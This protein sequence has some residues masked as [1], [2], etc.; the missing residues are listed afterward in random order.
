M[1]GAARNAKTAIDIEA[2][3]RE[4]YRSAMSIQITEISDA[5]TTMMSQTYYTLFQG[6]ERLERFFLPLMTVDSSG[7]VPFA[8]I[9]RSKFLNKC[10]PKIQ[11]QARAEAQERTWKNKKLKEKD[12]QKIPDEVF[13]ALVREELQNNSE[14]N[15]R[16]YFGAIDL[17]GWFKLNTSYAA[18]NFKETYRILRERFPGLGKEQ[19]WSDL[20]DK[21][22]DL[23][24]DW[25]GHYAPEDMDNVRNAGGPK[26]ALEKWLEIVERLHSAK[27]NEEEYRA[28]QK[29]LE[30]AVMVE[31]SPIIAF[32]DLG[33]PD[34]DHETIRGA[35][36]S[37]GIRCGADC[38]LYSSKKALSERLERILSN[39]HWIPLESIGNF[40]GDDAPDLLSF[41]KDC[42]FKVKE[43]QIYCSSA[44][45]VMK[46]LE[47]RQA[48]RQAE[49]DS[50][51]Q[52]RKAEE[53]R[54]KLKL[55]ERQLEEL[56][57]SDPQLYRKLEQ[58]GTARPEDLPRLEALAKYRKGDLSQSQIQ[59]LVRTHQIVLDPSILRSA[60]GRDFIQREL[61]PRIQAMQRAG[62]NAFMVLEA[63]ARYHLYQEFDA[64]KQAKQAYGETAWTA[65]QKQDQQKAWARI[66]EM[67]SAKAAYYFAE[68]ALHRQGLLRYV[69]IP[70]PE[71]EDGEALRLFLRRNP[72]LR[73]C[74]LTC[75]V[76]RQVTEAVDPEEFP[77]CAVARV[78]KALPPAKG[79]SVCQ[80]FNQFL[81][82]AEGE[83]AVDLLDT[84]QQYYQ[85]PTEN[86]A[87]S[88]FGGN[89]PVK[90]AADEEEK[91]GSPAGEAEK[92]D[93]GA[94][95]EEKKEAAP[96]AEAEKEETPP[97]EAEEKAATPA[98][99]GE[100]AA[101][102]P[103]KPLQTGGAAGTR[104]GPA[105]PPVSKIRR[106][107]DRALP[108]SRPVLI[109]DILTTETGEPVRLTGR[110]R[111]GK[112][113]VEG[114]EGALYQ[115]DL[116]EQVAKIYHSAPDK[117][118]LTSG[119]KAKLEDM[120]AH[121][122]EIQ[123]LCWPTHL[124]HNQKGEFV[125]YLM[126]RVPEGALSFQRSVLQM[127]KPYIQEAVLPGWNRRDLVRVAQA[128]ANMTAQLHQNNILIGDVNDGNFMVH[129]GDSGTVYL[130]DCDSYQF[131]GY[132]CPVGTL[133]YTHPNTA[134]RL[135][136]K[137]DLR[138]EEF[139]RLEEEED[140]T[141]GILL[142]RILML[143]QYPFDT[144]NNELSPAEAMRQKIFPFTVEEV[145]DIPEGDSWMIWKNMPQKLTK[146]FLDTFKEWKPPSAREWA[147]LLGNYLYSIDHYGYSRELSP[148]KYMEFH[149]EAP[150]FQDVVCEIDQVEFNMPVRQYERLVKQKGHI[151]CNGCR[152]FLNLSEKRPRRLTCEVCGKL[153]TGND[154]QLYLKEKLGEPVY[155]PEH[156][157][158]S[159][160]CEG[161]GEEYSVP[162]KEQENQSSR[163]SYCPQ[164]R[165]TEV[166]ACEVC[167]AEYGAQRGAYLNEKRYHHPG[168]CP[169]CRKADGFQL[170]CCVCR[171]GFW[172][173][174]DKRQLNYRY[175][176]GKGF[177]CD[178]H[179]QLRIPPRYN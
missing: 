162:R 112:E 94:P 173:K 122:P 76:S 166:Y 53:L 175:A 109:G 146:A 139:L 64:Y 123:N 22:K 153:F 77:L 129:P 151:L 75:G 84:L 154:R 23:R 59:E 52:V 177:Y 114:G 110:L 2:Q 25:T 172:L 40:M 165:K 26:K 82:L 41:L 16:A 164:C 67:T 81:P 143:A 27:V 117:Y 12:Y 130:V 127:F 20:C 119:R 92:P 132:P 113:N 57:S 74:V 90:A 171:E 100:K 44:D 13:S 107:E 116:P 115:V 8:V 69:G 150:F 102:P 21:A 99:A 125:G 32:D 136:I 45:H 33:R 56:R 168:L 163:R 54:R 68:D 121:N 131:D 47:L 140:Y 137:G 34:L 49:E 159:I 14:R 96:S 5:V 55:T 157:T 36:E 156:A 3:G 89:P 133:D 161:C 65:A 43:N 28:V 105:F 126:K 9:S 35:L 71:R 4:L 72:T 111:D 7:K 155:C 66:Q 29:A 169:A 179:L 19:K 31:E 48:Q 148:L 80:I 124:L 145:A 50:R 73:V 91:T 6:P 62:M 1:Q 167:G 174:G 38:T 51:L 158:V 144:R 63:T 18:A 79:G 106:V 24:N 170:N 118:R 70:N 141:L 78:M 142:F 97:A 93:A 61:V 58:Q 85:V 128:T 83:Q 10:S 101:V 86:Y 176:D 120:I 147:R 87:V 160:V 98:D 88:S 104:R 178:K 39:Y 95:S 30:R 15:A 135:G 108:L 60:E 37:D 103:P 138:F 149:P 46:V 134:A 11:E 152:R 17:A 42:G